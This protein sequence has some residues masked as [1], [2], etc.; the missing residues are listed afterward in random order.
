MKC[1]QV[2]QKSG[3]RREALL[4]GGRDELLLQCGYIIR[5][6]ITSEGRLFSGSKKCVRFVEG[7]TDEIIEVYSR[8]F[9]LVGKSYERGSSTFCIRSRYLM[10]EIIVL[11]Q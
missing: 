8:L 11:I 4:R 7:F 2:L 5:E 10:L 6:R 1:L 9:E 3:T